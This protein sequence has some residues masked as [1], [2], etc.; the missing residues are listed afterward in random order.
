MLCLTWQV[1]GSGMGD[2]TEHSLQ[3]CGNYSSSSTIAPRATALF[4][5]SVKNVKHNRLANVN[6]VRLQ[7]R[8]EVL[9]L[10][11]IWVIACTLFSQ[12]VCGAEL[13]LKT[14]ERAV[15]L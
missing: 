13:S 10:V 12:R 14:R 8:S 1:T 9:Q 15:S 2:Q 3:C 11:R 4:L 7:I 5:C 6:N